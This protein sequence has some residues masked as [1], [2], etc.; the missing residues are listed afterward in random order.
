MTDAE[1]PGPRRGFAFP[2]RPRGPGG[3]L[4]GRL[5]VLHVVAFLLVASAGIRIVAGA[6]LALAQESAAD[7]APAAPAGPVPAGSEEAL[8]LFEAVRG[9]EERLAAR[10]AEITRREGALAKAQADIEK[11]LAELTAAEDAL[12]KTIAQ[13]DGAAEEDV[14][15]LVTVYENMKP[16]DATALFAAMAPEFAAGFLG[17]MRPDAAAAIM[18]GL[19]P[20]AAYAI[21][22]TLAGRNAAAPSR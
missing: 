15:R 16:K 12:S 13:A 8:A 2:F 20:E 3:R 19:K 14:A 10:E 18:A 21:S 5:G 4:G 11:R 6:N 22:L 1:K 9:R 7:P 17:R